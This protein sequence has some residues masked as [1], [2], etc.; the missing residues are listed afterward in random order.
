M[1]FNTPPN[2]PNAPEGWMPDPGWTPESGWPAPP[3]GWRFWLNDYGVPVDGPPGFYGTR[4]RR[5]TGAGL[6]LAAGTGVLGLLFG[7]GASSEP[8]VRSARPVAEVV[9]ASPTI[10]ETVATPGPTVTATATKTATPKPAP[11]VTKTVTKEVEVPVPLLDSGGGGSD[12]S[13]YYDTCSDARAAGDTPL[14][15]GD[16]GYDSH[17]DRDND[18]VA[19]E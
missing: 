4:K 13:V 19:C 9:Q 5:L 7:V 12:S 8:T 3:A 1:R 11:T 14:Y 18:G 2:W 16:P 6:A 15:R 17:L 10:T